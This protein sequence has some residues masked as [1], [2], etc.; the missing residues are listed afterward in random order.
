MLYL[1]NGVNVRWERNLKNRHES[2]YIIAPIFLRNFPAT[3]FPI[4][5]K[6]RRGFFFLCT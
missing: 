4:L 1:C 5:H 2:A 6:S 3:T